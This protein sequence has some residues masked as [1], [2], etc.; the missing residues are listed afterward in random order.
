MTTEHLRPLLDDMRSLHLFFRVS[1]RLA[2]VQI[3]EVVADL[4]RLG[5]ITALSKPDGGV[6]GIVAGDVVRRLVARRIA[7]QLSTAVETSHQPSPV[8]TY[9][10]GGV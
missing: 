6:R 4:L 3:P 10:Q 8:R 5:R 1:E 2:R 7:K 9:N